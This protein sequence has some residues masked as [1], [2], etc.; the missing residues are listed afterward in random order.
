MVSISMGLVPLGNGLGRGVSI[1][2]GPSVGQ[3]VRRYYVSQLDRQP[4]MQCLFKPLV[5]LHE[6]HLSQSN[7]EDRAKAPEA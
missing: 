2:T 7:G 6:P 1:Q 5:L 3:I 4:M